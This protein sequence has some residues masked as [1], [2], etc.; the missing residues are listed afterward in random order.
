[1]FES[2]PGD[3]TFYILNAIRDVPVSWETPTARDNSGSVIVTQTT[4]YASGSRY[5]AGEY[6]VVYRAEDSSGNFAEC[7]FTIIVEVKTGK[8][9]DS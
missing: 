5:I 3:Q 6:T 7:T 4:V 9:C 8:F 1:M 2:C